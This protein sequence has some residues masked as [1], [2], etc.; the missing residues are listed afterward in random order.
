MSDI[1]RGK[2]TLQLRSEPGAVLISIVG[3]EMTAEVTIRSP[4]DVVAFVEALCVS[5]GKAFPD[6][7]VEKFVPLLE[8]KRAQ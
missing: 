1:A 4:G 8:R 7:D 3:I 2:G 5:V 6:L